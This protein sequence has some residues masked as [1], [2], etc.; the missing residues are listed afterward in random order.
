MFSVPLEYTDTDHKVLFWGTNMAPYCAT[1]TPFPNC[2]HVPGPCKLQHIIVTLVQNAV[3]LLRHVSH[4]RIKDCDDNILLATWNNYSGS[5]RSLSN[6]NGRTAALTRV[7]SENKAAILHYWISD[8]LFRPNTIFLHNFCRKS[9]SQYE[10]GLLQ[11]TIICICIYMQ[12][13]FHDTKFFNVS[14][15]TVQDFSC[16]RQWLLLGYILTKFQRIGSRNFS[17]FF[18]LLAYYLLTYIV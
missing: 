15:S 8:T 9:T 18:S 2:N 11:K 5:Q 12:I 4:S 16:G 6:G 1:S 10:L 17:A 3:E 14:C 7:L 13:I